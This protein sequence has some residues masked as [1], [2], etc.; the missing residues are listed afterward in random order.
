MVDVKTAVTALQS[1]A[2]IW[3]DAADDLDAPLKAISSLGLTGR[4]VSM[5]G[6]DRG[7]DTAYAS[8]QSALEDML[9]QAI[10]N[11]RN[12][13]GTLRKAAELYG[14]TETDNQQRIKDVLDN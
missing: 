11:F 12:L 6:V 2:D 10:Q 9:T 4:D 3:D 5:Y 14:Y 13:A 8:A 7:I 1:D